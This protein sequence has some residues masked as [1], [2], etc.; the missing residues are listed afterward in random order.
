MHQAVRA[1]ALA[2]VKPLPALLLRGD[3]DAMPA[4]YCDLQLLPN[5]DLT[6]GLPS[7]SA[8]DGSLH[9]YWA[10]GGTFRKWVL[11][12]D[13]SPASNVSEASIGTAFGVPPPC[14]E[15]TWHQW[16]YFRG[17]TDGEGWVEA[18][19]EAPLTLVLGREANERVEQLEVCVPTPSFFS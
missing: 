15:H 2:A 8:A 4:E 17:V 19:L 9:L 12:Q 16:A 7:W 6:N 14:G 18:C 11:N 1:A 10:Q 3:G 5:K 13:I